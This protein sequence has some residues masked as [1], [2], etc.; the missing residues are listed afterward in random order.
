M[1]E[2]VPKKVLVI[3]SGPIIIGQAA[4]FDYAGTQACKSLR[5]EGVEVILV[6]VFLLVRKRALED[7]LPHTVV[8]IRA[9]FM[10]EGW[11]RLLDCVKLIMFDVLLEHGFTRNEVKLRVLLIDKKPFESLLENTIEN[12]APPHSLLSTGLRQKVYDGEQALDVGLAV[13]VAPPF[14]KRLVSPLCQDPYVPCGE[15][16]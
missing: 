4:E 15:I 9:K 16:T 3:G 14:F 11:L 13:A 12:D 2:S 1:S 10:F 6:N 7:C 5:E 8:Q